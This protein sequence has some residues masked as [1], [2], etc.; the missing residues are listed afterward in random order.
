MAS[1]ALSFITLVFLSGSYFVFSAGTFYRKVTGNGNDA[2]VSTKGFHQ[3]SLNNECRNVG[4]PVSQ[5]D[6][7]IYLAKS[8]QE[9]EAIKKKLIIWEKVDK[10]DPTK[11][12]APKSQTGK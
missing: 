1:V 2:A 4:I 11:K 6:K 12:N 5:S 10:K 7:R 8:V 3:C 9:L